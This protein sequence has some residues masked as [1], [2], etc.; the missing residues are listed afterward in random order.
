MQ[1]GQEE[2]GC[3]VKVVRQGRAIAESYDGGRTWLVM[4][5]DGAVKSYGT[6]Q[7]AERGVKA[8]FRRHVD[9][10]AV[11]IGAIE[12]RTKQRMVTL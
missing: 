4:M 2:G 11:G 12:W 7:A 5:P 9:L 10:C 3:G 8:W 1:G 6:R